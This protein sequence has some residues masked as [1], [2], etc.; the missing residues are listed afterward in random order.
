T[1]KLAV[2][3]ALSGSVA[4]FVATAL[5]ATAVFRNLA[6]QEAEAQAGRFG[7][8][9]ARVALAPF[10]T[11]NLVRQDIAALADLHTAGTALIED[12]GAAH[13]KVWTRGGLILWADDERLHGQTFQLEEAELALFDTLGVSVELSRLDN[14]ENQFD[15]PSGAGLLEVYFAVETAAGE[16]LLVETYYPGTIVDD[17]AS[18]YRSRFMPLLLGGLVLLTLAQVQLVILLSRRLSR[19]R[20][21]RERL[22]DQVISVSDAERRRIAGE[23]HDGAV[24]E[25]IGIAYGLSAAADQAP[26]SLRPTLRGLAASAR[27]TTR[28]LRSLLMSIY[29]YEVPED[30]WVAGL[31]DL[32]SS[33]QEHGVEVEIRVP[34]RRLAPVEEQLLLRVSREALRNVSAHAGASRVLIVVSQQASGPLLEITDDGVGF[35]PNTLAESRRGGHL[36]LQL[37]SDLAANVGAD[38]DVRSQPGDGTTVRLELAGAK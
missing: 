19:L 6:E 29:P 37:L 16:P 3:L 32:I 35:S 18:S 14:P 12:G 13:V 28:S 33:L 11:D 24:Q 9:A 1:T 21:D 5:I 22:L 10:L 8:A 7:E 31:Q 26:E 38:L 20:A 17:L 4:V 30:G 34:D 15:E 23:V 27:N 25:L 2:V 36:G